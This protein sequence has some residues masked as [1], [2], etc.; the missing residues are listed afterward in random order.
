MDYLSRESAPF[1]GELWDKIDEAV[2][3]SARRILVGRRF[4]TIFGPL[5]AG[6]QSINIDSEK[7]A[8]TSKDGVVR[9]TG[10]QYAEIPQVY[11][12]FFMLWRDI[13]ASEKS[14]YPVDI[15]SAM[16][17]AESLSR[18]EDK[19]IFFGDKAL[20]VSGIL[21]APGANKVKRGDWATGENA[22]TDIAKGI[23]ILDEKGYL[24]R[25]ALVLSP[26]LYLDLQRIQ[27]G[28]G[29]MEI[30]RVGRMVD[31]RV[32]RAPVLGTKTAVL[33]CC[34]PQYMDLVIGVDMTTSY[35]ELVDLNHHMRVLETVLPRI[36]RQDAIVV[37]G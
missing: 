33:V 4:L 24:G 13:E 36:K 32:F 3:D 31:G 28:T 30:D 29:L 27:P 37:F 16:A 14:G 2:V 26:D 19:L 1:S 21:N 7:K 9:T 34:E 18:R 11:D 5:G 8:E 20:G 17:A 12:D 23:S 6:A 10:R 25:Y 15:S 22:F 35:L